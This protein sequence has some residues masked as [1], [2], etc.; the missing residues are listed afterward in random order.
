MKRMKEKKEKKVKKNKKKW[1][2]VLLFFIIL[3]LI[4]A[5]LWACTGGGG[6]ELNMVEVSSLE[7][8]SIEEVVNVN[9]V[10][11]SEDVRTYFA[12]VGG[13]LAEVTI[14]AGDVVSAGEML[15]TYNVEDLEDA[16]EQARL[17]YVLDNSSYQN[18][19]A[20]NKDAQAKLTEA[21]INIPVL[22]K[23]ITDEK[24]NVK[25]LQDALEA[26]QANKTNTLAYQAL[27]LQNELVSLENDPVANAERIEEIQISLQ[28][29]QTQS[30]LIETAGEEADLQKKLSEAQERLAGYEEYLAE[31]KA[32]KQEASMDALSD[33]Q[34]ENLSVS[35]Q[36]N[37]IAYENAQKDFDIAQKGISAEFSGVIT[38]LSAI[39][40]MPVMEDAQLL[41]L[42]SNE[43]V[44]V[45]F[46]V[47][48]YDLARI[49][50]G[51]TADIEIAD[52]MYTGSITKINHVAT[53]SNS[54]TTQ[55]KAE[56]HIDNP[57]EYVYLGLD[58]K[59]KIHAAE[60]NDVLLLPIAALYADK[61][62]D[63]VYV[64]ENGIA[65]RKNIVTGISSVEYIEVK[66]GLTATDK[67]I[68]SAM[69]TLEEGMPVVTNEIIA[70]EQV[71][72]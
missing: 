35:E 8:G 3:I 64:E 29:I 56:I 36:L 37:L 48:T 45:T 59:V 46:Y 44:K 52:R 72:P 9:G 41:T 61:E 31:M 50:V 54:G 49:A 69:V 18:T 15:I 2:K 10:V 67:V 40:G 28:C 51:Q 33:L 43:N 16:L 19:L 47:G 26:V 20:N 38:E 53:Q 17:Q 11:E 4:V 70:G 13:K 55:L 27:Q 32:Q 66:E 63:F 57:D 58:A 39:E 34:K 65:V 1:K 68:V 71:A 14:E 42:A 23:Q 24:A 30:Q 5:G 12:P 21:N 25:E 62:S 6:S 22:E 7:T 60:V